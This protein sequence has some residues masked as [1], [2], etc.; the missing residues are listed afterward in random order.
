MNKILLS[1]IF[2]ALTLNAQPSWFYNI[3]TKNNEIIGYG[4]SNDLYEAKKYAIDEI[5][6]TLNLNI[7]SSYDIKKS[8]KKD[9]L[10]KKEISSNIN[11]K[12]R[13]NL[14]DIYFRYVK[15]IDNQWYV[16]AVYDNSTLIQKVQSRL[17]NNNL[18]NEKQNF[19]LEKS[20][21]IKS[22]NKELNYKL[23]FE[24]IRKN[25]LWY[26]SYKNYLFHLEQND[27]YELFYDYKN[28]LI[29]STNKITFEDN[30]QIKLTIQSKKDSFITIFNI[31]FDGKIGILMKNQKINNQ[32]IIDEFK[33]INPYNK[34]IQE[35]FIA[36]ESEKPIDLNNYTNIDMKLLNE[37]DFKLAELLKL[38]NNYN[39]SSKTIKINKGY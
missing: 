13:N 1:L 3:K 35:Q 12:S 28:D 27:F 30:E 8:Y 20:P 10:V 33:T 32:K 7:D 16:A 6:K 5:S 17:K 4:V 9:V 15:K 24:I 19:Y 14:Q 36:I 38:L 34:Q 22:L 11:I 37:N 39:Y 25:E 23:N 18:R 26:L 31:Q 2:L 29:V 21:L